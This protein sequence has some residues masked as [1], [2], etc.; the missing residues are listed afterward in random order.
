MVLCDHMLISCSTTEVL[1][2]RK[3]V[4]PRS[5]FESFT[6]SVWSES[7]NDLFEQLERIQKKKHIM[8][9]DPGLPVEGGVI[10][11]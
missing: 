4:H 3:P 6:L 2:S 7:E 8:I 10:L 5:L 9:A 11:H 1:T